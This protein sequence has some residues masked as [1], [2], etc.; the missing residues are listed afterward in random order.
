M[1]LHT[2][3]LGATI[4]LLSLR[5]CHLTVRDDSLNRPV[6]C[7]IKCIKGF[8]LFLQGLTYLHWAPIDFQL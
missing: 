5:I 2:S 1:A 3:C 4:L 7:D 6:G 8:D